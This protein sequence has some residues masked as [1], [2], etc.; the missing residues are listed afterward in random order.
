MDV[1]D[2]LALA[3]E[4]LM[5]FYDNISRKRF[6]PAASDALHLC[7]ML[8]SAILRGKGLPIPRSHRGK[9]SMISRIDPVIH[10]IYHELQTL[11]SRMSYEGL[12]GGLVKRLQELVEELV[13]RVRGIYGLR[14]CG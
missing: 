11:Y 12:N 13:S 3:C 1:V 9:L 8:V 4:Y 14:M 10:N 7:D 5:S 6:A 2:Y